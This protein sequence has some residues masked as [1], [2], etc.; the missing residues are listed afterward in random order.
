MSSKSSAQLGYDRIAVQAEKSDGSCRKIRVSDDLEINKNG[1][2]NYRDYDRSAPP[3][4][5]VATHSLIGRRN[6][7]SAHWALFETA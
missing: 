7:S 4:I 3:S 2:I 5:S 6:I 1:S